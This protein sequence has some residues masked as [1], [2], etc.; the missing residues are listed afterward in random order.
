MSNEEDKTGVKIFVLNQSNNSEED[1]L[2]VT[3][4][5]A[6]FR[7][8]RS[9]QNIFL[10][11]FSQQDSLDYESNT[12]EDMQKSFSMREYA[13]MYLIRNVDDQMIVDIYNHINEVDDW[14][15]VVLPMNWGYICF[16]SDPKISFLIFLSMIMQSIMVSKDPERYQSLSLKSFRS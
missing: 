11:L 15:E 13:E 3:P 6:A 9:L 14:N 7:I 10:E 4:T 1:D 8:A 2:L 5:I 16:Q 12:I